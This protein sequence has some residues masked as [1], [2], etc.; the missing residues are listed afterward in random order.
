VR[1]LQTRLDAAARAAA[2]AAQAKQGE[3]DQAHLALAQAHEAISKLQ[4]RLEAAAS[5]ENRTAAATQVR[6]QQDQATI[7]DLQA[8][9]DVAGGS[10]REAAEAS[11][12]KLKQI[13]ESNHE[14]RERLLAAEQA[15]TRVTK[16]SDLLQKA[17]ADLRL[18]QSDSAKSASAQTAP[19]VDRAPSEPKEIGGGE[20]VMPP[21]E[22]SVASSPAIALVAAPVEQSSATV[23]EEKIGPVPSESRGEHL[24][25]TPRS[26]AVPPVTTSSKA[27]SSPH[28]TSNEALADD[29]ALTSVPRAK[30][31][32]AR[33]AKHEK[34][35]RD[36]Q[37]DLFKAQLE[38]GQKPANPAA[39]ARAIASAEDSRL[40]AN[41]LEP[42]SAAC[43][44]QE[45]EESS[46][47]HSMNQVT[48]QPQ[49]EPQAVSAGLE[50]HSTTTTVPLDLP[51]IEGFAATDGL[52]RAGANP[53]LYFK[54]LQ[55][56]V[57]HQTGTPEKIRKALLQ[58][59]L[60]GVE[61]M[62]QSFKTAA[63]DIGATTA[64]SAAAALARATHEQAD[65]GEIESRWEELAKVV[66]DLVADLKHVLKPR[67]GKPAPA[68]RPPAL[69]PVNPAQL[70]KA[71]NEIFP[72]LADQDPGAKDCLKANRATFRSAFSSEAYVE[73]EQ[74]VKRGDFV[75]AL[76]HLK[77]AAKKHGISI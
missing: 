18:L 4:A 6:L 74:F 73:F 52:A 38:E 34:V 57:D 32:S 36:D 16:L 21:V 25:A 64:Q 1:E 8:R 17:Q 69:P 37:I 19:L 62:V 27:E 72:L 70:R 14:L 3:F 26:L 55:R 48:V 10:A 15:E 31:K 53:K 71:V 20:A 51:V 50:N 67:E 49:S 12:D 44:P 75:T 40:P 58:G 59:D 29:T 22:L 46:A 28:P 77:K 5:A 11:A 45:L 61:R 33:M 76:E 56:F 39:D 68:R 7:A 23:A 43:A 65:P 60:A 13:E 63:G 66:R 30:K 2:E 54:A 24:A 42:T 35:R 41:E 47:G 9:L